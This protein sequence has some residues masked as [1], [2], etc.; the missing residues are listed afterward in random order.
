MTQI[1]MKSQVAM[2]SRRM[3]LSEF[4]QQVTPNSFLALKGIVPPVAWM[5]MKCDQKKK[6]GKWLKDD[7]RMAEG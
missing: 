1:P 2:K 6:I 5:G 4:T 7:W 3:M